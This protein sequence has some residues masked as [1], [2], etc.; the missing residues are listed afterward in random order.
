MA[1]HFCPEEL[2]GRRARTVESMAKAGLDGMPLFRP[3]SLYYLTG[4]EPLSAA[5]FDF[6]AG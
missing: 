1:L 6:V 2:A 3:E 5:G 4:A